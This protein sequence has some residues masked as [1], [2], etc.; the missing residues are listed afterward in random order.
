MTLTV[1]IEHIGSLRR[2]RDTRPPGTE[3]LPRSTSS[4]VFTPTTRTGFTIGVDVGGT[5]VAYGLFNG[6]RELTSRVQVPADPSASPEEF[7]DSIVGI[8]R[9]LAEDQG[10]KID[11]LRGIGIGMP[12]YVLYEEGRIIKTAN[13]PLLHDVPARSYLRAALG[14]SVRVL[15]DNDAHTGA[16]AEHRHGAGR[17]FRHMLYCPVSTGISSGIIINND[18]FRGRYGW[19]GESG[20]MIVTPGEG[21]ECGC[22]NRGCLMSY[23]SGSMI[24]KHVRARLEAGAA[25][26]MPELAGGAQNI[27]ARTLEEAWDADDELARWAVEQMARYMAVWTYNLY[28]LLNINC[29]VFGG[30]LL[31]F[32]DRLFPR[33]RELFDAY[34]DNDMP[35]YFK[36]AELGN[37]F[38]IIGAAELMFQ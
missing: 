3:T 26:M 28:V 32:G 30:G 6:E 34:N 12:S 8:C 9:A 20:H 19:A 37:D 5:K 1:P 13:L 36:E 21:I 22:G 24:V 7:L 16:L 31:N 27:T 2:Q 38:G 15:I 25:S 4:S 17:G 14:G 35:V 29:F 23:C 10:L 18:L 11:E 33:V